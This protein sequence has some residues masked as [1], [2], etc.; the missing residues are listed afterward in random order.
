[1]NNQHQ[2]YYTQNKDYAD[3]LNNQD[4]AFFD[5][6]IKALAGIPAGGKILD[7][8]CG[9]GQVVARLDQM[10]FEAYGIEVSL[11]NVEM[12]LKVSD[13]CS[14]YDG[15]R[16]PFDDETFDAVGSFNVLEHV[17]EPEAYIRE[18]VRVLR[19]G[20]RIVLSSP[21]FHR[22]IGFRDYHPH[23]RGLANKVKNART[24]AQKWGR[25]RNG[26]TALQ[27]DRMDPI[28]REHGFN[29]DDDAII[30]TNGLEMAWQLKCA[31]IRITNMHCTDRIVPPFI[32]F[33]LNCSPLK[34]LMFNAFVTGTKEAA[35]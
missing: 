29:P 16:V 6:Y 19:P 7:A 23:M 20:G 24:L 18:L 33:A 10:G 15:K 2:D 26:N 21:N 12:A 14:C 35:S 28:Q 25:I 27:F 32:E 1:M 22:V 3:F 9:T 30:A 11:P 31:G 13:R 4:S 5:K 8:G 34:Y 17:D